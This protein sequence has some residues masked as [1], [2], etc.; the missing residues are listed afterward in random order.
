M[1]SNIKYKAEFI[2]CILG[3][4]AVN[5]ILS[6]SLHDWLAE[7]LLP[8]RLSLDHQLVRLTWCSRR[9]KRRKEIPLFLLNTSCSVTHRHK[10]FL[11][12]RQ[13]TGS[14]RG[15]WQR[16]GFD[17]PENMNLSQS[18]GWNWGNTGI[19]DWRGIFRTINDWSLTSLLIWACEREHEWHKERM[20]ESDSV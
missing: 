16:G 12:L 19:T 4:D 11:V 18:E 13:F 20:K 14:D 8:P 3:C 10:H 2:S 5:Q 9:R 6:H 7:H 17:V 15:F 1:Q